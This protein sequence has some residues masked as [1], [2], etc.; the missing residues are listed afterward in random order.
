MEEI[1]E[2]LHMEL[3]NFDDERRAEWMRE[4]KPFSVLF[5]LTARCNMN[6]IHCYLQ[7]H[8]DT[9]LLSYQEITGIID[10]LYEKGILFLTLTGGEILTRPDFTDIYLYAKKKG[11]FVE[12]FTNG[13][14]FTDEIIRILAEYPPLLV[15]ISLYGACEDT[16]YRVTGVRGAFE[17]VRENCR[18]LKDAGI[19]VSLKTPVLKETLGE[20]AAMKALAEELDIQFVYTFEICDTIDQSGAPKE[21]AVPLRE[22]LR[23]EFENYYEQIRRGERVP[24]HGA[25]TGKTDAG[26]GNPG[27]PD[28][29]GTD[30]DA[31]P[32]KPD[33]VE[34][35]SDGA[36]P[37]MSGSGS[38]QALRQAEERRTAM[39]ELKRSRLV[40]AC[41]VA[42]N[43]FVID[44]RGRI[45]PCMKLRHRGI[46]LNRENYD[47]IWEAF[48][49]YGRLKASDTY[50][51]QGCDARYYCDVCP[52]EMDFLYGDME[53]R[54][55]E[56]CRCAKIRKA[57]YEGEVTF[58]EALHMASFNEY[59]RKG[60]VDDEISE[61]RGK[62]NGSCGEG[63]YERQ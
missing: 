32:G 34:T 55:K 25:I 48:R 52:A 1:N 54:P 16:Y 26:C 57:F 60:G 36:K 22:V 61:A 33:D 29:V 2:K 17:R 5:E 43:S 46:R 58:E 51:C 50:I 45:L 3:L 8:H 24:L 49:L 6:C 12:L 18:K 40:Y 21:L 44:Y 35:D 7:N 27:K 37:G 13:Y 42:Q 62:E 19:R 30:S 31:G 28:D 20:L 11:F 56:L 63:K 38:S 14:L 4:R 10:L 59:M 53:Y 41:N 15:D 9:G 47:E 23:Y 39:A